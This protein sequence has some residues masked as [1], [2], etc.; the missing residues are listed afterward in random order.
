MWMLYASCCCFVWWRYVAKAQQRPS[1]LKRSRRLSYTRD[2]SLRL[3]AYFA[4]G[5]QQ[6]IHHVPVHPTFVVHGLPAEQ[7]APHPVKGA[8]PEKL[9]RSSSSSSIRPE[10]CSGI[11]LSCGALR[12]SRYIG[13]FQALMI[14]SRVTVFLT[15]L[16]VVIV[17]L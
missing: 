8:P 16:D 2:T 7:P 14:C 6:K 11:E 5:Q 10:G 17:Q 12:D 3:R 4:R 15:F 13:S 1:W 9:N